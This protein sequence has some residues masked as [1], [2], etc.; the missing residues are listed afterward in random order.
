MV[1]EPLAAATLGGV[2]ERGGSGEEIDGRKRR[3]EEVSQWV[4]PG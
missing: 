4:G 3:G 2:E 1:L